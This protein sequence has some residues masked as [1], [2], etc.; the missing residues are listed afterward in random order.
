MKKITIFLFTFLALIATSTTSAQDSGLSLHVGADLLNRYVWRGTDFGNSP[1][2]Q[3]G[4]E[5]SAGNLS[6]GAWGS[7]SLSANTTG[8]EADLYASYSMPFGL[9]IIFTDYYFPAEPGS[10]GNYFDYENA[11][12]FEI[13]ATQSIGGFYFAGYYYLNASGDTY[14]ETGY[15]NGNFSIFAGGGDNSYT[16]DTEFG[17]CNIGISASKEVSVTESF[18]LPLT[19][20]VILNP[21]KE[22]IF[23]VVGISL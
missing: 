8:T 20:R 4:I 21:D 7:Y 12:T 9:D 14:F 18:S 16:T 13:G 3:P 10:T 6:I 5:L 22:Q 23:L 2:V 1:V 19:G 17:I 15:S 11:H